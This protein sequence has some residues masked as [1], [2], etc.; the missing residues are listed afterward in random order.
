MPNINEMF[1]SKYLKAADLPE[2]GVVVTMGQVIR[3]EIE[4]GKPMYVLHFQGKDRGLV[5]NKTNANMIG[6]IFGGQTEGWKGHQITLVKEPVSFQGKIVDAIRVKP[7]QSFPEG[8]PDV[9]PPQQQAPQAAPQ[10]GSEGFDD[11]I[12]F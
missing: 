6:H 11:D 12:P 2:G 5:L 7:A 10:T 8:G 4:P 1:P 9:M 3:E